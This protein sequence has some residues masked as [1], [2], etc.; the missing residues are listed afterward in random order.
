MK[1]VSFTETKAFKKQS[2]ERV[3]LPSSTVSSIH[4][5]KSFDEKML[6]AS[7]RILKWKQ[8][9]KALD[10][11]AKAERAEQGEVAWSEVSYKQQKKYMEDNLKK[12]QTYR[13]NLLYKAPDGWDP[14]IIKDI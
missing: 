5:E 2:Q 11:A 3:K 13:Y 14:V 10:D 4:E 1:F 6:A 7:E 8:A 9:I 12:A